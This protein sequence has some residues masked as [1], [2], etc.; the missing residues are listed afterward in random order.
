MESVQTM[1]SMSRLMVFARDSISVSTQ[2]LHDLW[3]CEES[4]QTALLSHISLAL[5]ASP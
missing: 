1:K 2:V 5:R 4:A 3:S